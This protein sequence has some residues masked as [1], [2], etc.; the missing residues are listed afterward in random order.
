MTAP[1]NTPA[2]VEPPEA[3]IERL[4][5]EP[6]SL[7]AGHV[8][9]DADCLS[10]MFALAMGLEQA[11]GRRS[12]CALPK[13]S[14]SDKLGFLLQLADVALAD[15]PTCR[16][17]Q[18]VAVCDTAKARRTNLPESLSQ[19]LEQ[20]RM[21]INIDHHASN[22]RFGALNWVDPQASSTAEMIWRLF[23][24]AAWTLTPSI[25]TLLYAGIHADTVGF[26]LSTT[27]A[28]TLHAAT[29]L[30]R[31]G[32]DID[33]VGNRLCRTQSRSEFDLRRVV[34]DNTLVTASGRIAYS[35]ADYREIT[36]AGCTAADI[37]DQV[38]I[39]RSLA[40]TDLAI[41]FTEGV[42]GK[43]RINLRG[44]GPVDALGLAQQVG[45]GGHRAAAGAIMNGTLDQVI[46]DLIPRAETYLDEQQ[47]NPEHAAGA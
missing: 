9:P 45:G 36:R 17:A 41:L 19:D 29:A 8:T 22:T 46:A 12:P 25:A 1:R 21:V 2:A 26:S 39:P 31:A 3:L 42:P 40:G 34:Y 18:T 43:I 30:A 16:S 32:A 20:R 5:G 47:R 37:D 24:R 44:K 15:A 10:S 28:E 7:I 38:E 33:H 4:V 6:V 27:T 14:V 35:R 11:T 23:D 13:P